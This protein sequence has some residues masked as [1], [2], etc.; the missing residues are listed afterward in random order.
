MKTAN[1]ILLILLLSTNK[2]FAQ[3]FNW[4]YFP[5]EGKFDRYDSTIE[6][7]EDSKGNIYTIGYFEEVAYI[8]GDTLTVDGFNADLLIVK[9][10]PDRT[11]AWYKEIDLN[12]YA[13]YFEV[14]LDA[15]ENL[16]LAGEYEG[17]VQIDDFKIELAIEQS[18]FIAKINPDGAVQWLTSVLDGYP[19]IH[20]MSLD[21][22]G[23]IY[24]A[25]EGWKGGFLAML[26]DVGQVH[27]RWDINSP[28]GGNNVWGADIK[29]APDGSVYGLLLWQSE[30]II[31]SD[32]VTN[33]SPYSWGVQMTLFKFTKDGKIIWYDQNKAGRFNDNAFLSVD[34]ESNV[35]IAGSFN[36][37]DL[38]LG[39]KSLPS[40]NSNRS[41]GFLAKCT[42]DKEW[43]WI[44]Q[45]DPFPNLSRNM[46][47]DCKKAFLY[48]VGSS[49]LEV[50]DTKGNLLK[51]HL[52]DSN[53][54][55]PHSISLGKNNELLFC[56]L[57]T[58]P[59]FKKPNAFADLHPFI[60]SM[61]Y[62]WDI[63]KAP[64]APIVPVKIY[65]CPSTTPFSIYAQGD[66]I[67]WFKGDDLNNVFSNE[68]EL[69]LS[70]P[71]SAIYYVSQFSNGCESKKASVKVV[72]LNDLAITLDSDTLYA[73][74]DANFSYEWLLDGIIIP[75]ATTAILPIDSVGTYTVNISVA[76]CEF[77]LDYV[78]MTTSIA[79]TSIPTIKLAPTIFLELVQ[80]ENDNTDKKVTL[81]IYNLLGHVVLTQQLFSTN[82]L[83]H[84]SHLPKGVYFFNL[85]TAKGY[86]SKKL[87]K[88]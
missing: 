9:Y 76:D 64:A 65:N 47:F 86:F 30:R 60:V 62:D 18:A 55:Y 46:L 38:K 69:I 48:A 66:S 25:G 63:C 16:I 79:Q 2:L 28:G 17:I 78:L 82:N 12:E 59:S 53:Q 57:T 23:N 73:P 70:N 6:I 41:F 35:Y 31:I 75:A 5:Y 4:E 3:T 77:K 51:Q 20:A 19:I 56:G 21:D 34:K 44:T 81:T 24:I 52:F 88:S 71:D 1:L 83:I 10:H 14:A 87:I 43:E 74:Y 84:T 8:N 11:V 72:D 32:N 7:L 85:K 54:V 13:R 29:K 68:N 22:Y 45:R 26:N 15:R 39:D 67:T 42:P 49:S 33:Y 36:N 50:F 58:I 40:P 80:I 27:W 37:A 61:D